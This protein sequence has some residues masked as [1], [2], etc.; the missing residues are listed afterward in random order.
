MNQPNKPK[1]AHEEKKQNILKVVNTY[2][3]ITATDI[4]LKLGLSANTVR[5]IIR[6]LLDGNKL[7]V[8]HKTKK[9]LQSYKIFVEDDKQACTTQWRQIPEGV[10]TGFTWEPSVNR[11]GCDD[12][13][14]CP[15]RLG[16][17]LV[18]YRAPIYAATPSQHGGAL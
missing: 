5:N 17:N 7:A 3:A 4:A 15:S 14:K 9:R 10:F 18:P 13:L 6:E 1:N 16:D 12:F 8:A 2:K 11:P